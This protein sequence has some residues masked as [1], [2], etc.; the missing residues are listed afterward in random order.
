MEEALKHFESTTLGHRFF[1]TLGKCRTCGWH[2]HVWSEADDLI[3]GGMLYCIR[4]L[5]MMDS[6]GLTVD[7]FLKAMCHIHTRRQSLS[8]ARPPLIFRQEG[9]K[10][11]NDCRKSALR[12]RLQFQL[13]KDEF[14]VLTSSSTSCCVFC[15]LQPPP[16]KRLGLDRVHNMRGYTWDNVQPSC[17]TCNRLKW[18]FSNDFFLSQ[19][20]RIYSSLL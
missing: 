2:G 6:S 1:S 3:G 18:K 8:S 15:G 9:C 19:C 12:R 11:Y 17:T 7:G 14:H 10:T 13:S 16:G 20:Q 4:C 5:K